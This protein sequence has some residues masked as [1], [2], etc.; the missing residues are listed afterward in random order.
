MT[1][2]RIK[3]RKSCAIRSRVTH[4]QAVYLLNKTKLEGKTQSDII[5]ELIENDRTMTKAKKESF[6]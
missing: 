2:E 6:S 1:N 4:E 3:Q 5:R